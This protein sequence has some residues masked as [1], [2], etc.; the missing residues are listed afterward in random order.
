M[1]SV[2]SCLGRIQSEGRIHIAK[3][4]IAGQHVRNALFERVVLAVPYHVASSG[5][6][7]CAP[8]AVL[9]GQANRNVEAQARH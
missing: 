3:A 6:H 1:L 2:F 5:V 9:K 4:T 8:W 7:H